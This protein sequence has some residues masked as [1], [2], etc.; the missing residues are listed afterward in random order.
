MQKILLSFLLSIIIYSCSKPD[1]FPSRPTPNPRPDTTLN[2]VTGWQKITTSYT[3]VISDVW[4]INERDGFIC[5]DFGMA[6]SNDSGKTWQPKF[7]TLNRLINISFLNNQIG[8]SHSP[9][10]IFITTNSGLTWSGKRLPFFG[11]IDLYFVTPAV[12]F[13]TNFGSTGL[14]RTTDTAKTWTK[15]LDGVASAVFFFNTDTGFTHATGGHI[16]KTTDGG[17]TWHQITSSSL[18]NTN[19]EMMRFVTTQTGWLSTLEGL[20]KTTDGGM[21]WTKNLAV[22]N[23]MST[24][25]FNDSIGFASFHS[26][27]YYTTDGG[28]NWKKE[29][30]SIA[31]ALLFELNFVNQNAGW[32]CGTNGLL[33][34][35]RK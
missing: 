13:I 20:F 23:A 21:T 30:L 12:G 25:F 10:S 8:Y 15:V 35:Y 2:S 7:A 11:P 32:S 17:A 18:T 1:D 5:G 33:L 26:D 16:F 31:P 4:F 34:R 28:T 3:G 22:A 14:Y 24:H 27:I 19:W 29:N 6:F 9:D